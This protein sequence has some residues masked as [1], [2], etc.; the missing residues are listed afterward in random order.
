MSEADRADLR[1]VLVRE[2]SATSHQ[3]RSKSS[4]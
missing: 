2:L 4:F 1:D 3:S